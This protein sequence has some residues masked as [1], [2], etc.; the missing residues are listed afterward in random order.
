[1]MFQGSPETQKFLHKGQPV[2]LHGLFL[3]SKCYRCFS[4][5]R[6]RNTA[7]HIVGS[8]VIIGI[9]SLTV[10]RNLLCGK[11]KVGWHGHK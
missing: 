10:D 5:N 8:S 3:N 4:T 6:E 9:M 11:L 2:R 1:M 7:N